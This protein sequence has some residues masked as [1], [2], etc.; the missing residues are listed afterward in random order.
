MTC[1]GTHSHIRHT[2]AF[3]QRVAATRETTPFCTL[4]CDLSL[5]TT[6]SIL[7]VQVRLN[8]S[9]L[10][11]RSRMWGLS[12][13]ALWAWLVYRFAHRGLAEACPATDRGLPRLNSFH[14]AMA[15]VECA[16]IRIIRC[17]QPLL[18]TA[19][20]RDEDILQGIRTSFEQHAH[21]LA[22]ARCA[23]IHQRRAAVSATE[24][25]LAPL[26]KSKR[27]TSSWPAAQV[28]CRGVI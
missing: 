2:H 14:F 10:S 7:L 21:T 24:S 26:S 20:V 9:V 6:L 3:L 22:V 16:Q 23:G 15:A 11:A 5:S 17:A 4:V 1:D 25:K 27:A 8:P 19:G 13:A 28:A 12:S 18:V